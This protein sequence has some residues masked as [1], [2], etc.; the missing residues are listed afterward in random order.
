MRRFFLFET[1]V[2]D[3]ASD[4]LG[5]RVDRVIAEVPRMDLRGRRS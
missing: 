4:Q 1:A 5:E 2:V 3:G